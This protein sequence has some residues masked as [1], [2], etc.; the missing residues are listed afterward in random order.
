LSVAEKPLQKTYQ[1]VPSLANVELANGL[2]P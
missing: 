1:T 2:M